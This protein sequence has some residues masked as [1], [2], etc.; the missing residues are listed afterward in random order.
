MRVARAGC[1]CTPPAIPYALV[2][3]VT[4]I[5]R[6]MSAN[7]PVERAATLEDVRAEVLA[8]ERLNAFVLSGFAGVAL[9]IAVVGVAGVLAFSVSARTREFGVRLAVG[10]TPRHLLMRVLSEGALIVAIGIVAG[11][12]G[13]YAFAGVAASYLET[14][15][16]AGRAAD[17]WRGGRPRRRCR[18]RFADARR[19]SVARGR[20][21]GAQIGIDQAHVRPARDRVH[22]AHERRRG[23]TGRARRAIVRA[24]TGS[25][26]SWTC[27][28]S[29]DDALRSSSSRLQRPRESLAAGCLPLGHRRRHAPLPALRPAVHSPAITEFREISAGDAPANDQESL[30]DPG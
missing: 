25:A 21:A 15:A 14:R 28:R 16:A 7:Q 13:G 27:I 9:L 11:A 8:P 26:R 17:P 6:E 19:E 12:A 30:A 29:R 22:R 24:S 1:S 5:I 18:P 10:S 20:A 3:P 4:R 2:P 23:R